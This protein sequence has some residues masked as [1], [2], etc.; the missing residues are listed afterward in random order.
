MIIDR[1]NLKIEV[2]EE[3][4]FSI[5]KS[6]KI[7]SLALLTTLDPDNF[8]NIIR[9]CLWLIFLPEEKIL[10]VG[11]GGLIAGHLTV[12][13]FLGCSQ[14]LLSEVLL[15]FHFLM[16]QLFQSLLLVPLHPFLEVLCGFFEKDEASD[17]E[18]DV[19]H[20]DVYC[21]DVA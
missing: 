7:L 20:S 9:H 8:H 16:G 3:G 18:V 6:R 17:A 5:I 14:Y 11:D 12:Q 4:F 15:I 2:N 21:S 19:D 10:F 1:D 13:L